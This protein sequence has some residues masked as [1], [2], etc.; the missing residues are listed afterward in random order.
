MKNLIKIAIF[1]LIITTFMSCKQIEKIVYV[2]EIHT[3]Y[4]N[5]LKYDSIYLKDSIYFSKIG[6]T[7]YLQKFKYVNKYSYLHDTIIKI[8]TITA[9]KNVETIKYINQQTKWQ[10]IKINAFNYLIIA[11]IGALIFAF[12]KQ[13]WNLFK[14]IFTIIKLI[15]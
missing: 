14:K 7:I 11:I 12:R 3:E 6:D 4:K 10:K 15:I 1:S 5:T 9:I 13:I 8:D 2:P